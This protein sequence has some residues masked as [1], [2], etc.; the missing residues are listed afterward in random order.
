MT[1]MTSLA[2]LP[3]WK[4]VAGVVQETLTSLSLLQVNV[5]WLIVDRAEAAGHVLLCSGSGPFSSGDVV[6]WPLEQTPCDCQDGTLVGF[7]LLAPSGSAEGYFGLWLPPAYGA[8]KAADLY[9]LRAK[10]GLFAALLEQLHQGQ[11]LINELERTRRD[12]ETD[13]LTGLFNRRGW[14]R[15]LEREQ[16]RC[17]RYGCPC[18]LMVIDLDYL[19][20]VNDSEG[21]H[22]GDRLLRRMACVL[23]QTVRQP[24]VVA[25][26]GGDEF[27]VLLAETDFPQAERFKLR[28]EVALAEAGI[29][30]SMGMAGWRA[31]ESLCSAVQRADEAMYSNKKARSRG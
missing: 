9:L 19:K 26:V 13:S 7:P 5:Q 17:E 23:E 12:A 18:T 4:H 14:S 24:D 28:L 10:A 2:R 27:A 1:T 31:G 8:P 21:H 3:Q 22:A 25:R 16:A 30:A 11:A 29:S 15:M 6:D 20:A